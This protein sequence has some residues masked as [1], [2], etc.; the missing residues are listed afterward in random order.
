MNMTDEEMMNT[1]I[2]TSW[3]IYDTEGLWEHA[4]MH[5]HRHRR[6][7]ELFLSTREKE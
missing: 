3:T 2:K 7:M 1:L 5:I 6:Q 4:V